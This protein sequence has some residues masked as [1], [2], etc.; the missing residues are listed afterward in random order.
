MA[1]DDDLE[2]FE[3]FDF[4][5]LDIDFD[6]D[7]GSLDNGKKRK[8][9]DRHPIEDTIKD[10]YNAAVDN[11]KSKK[12]RDHASGI[13][14]K[15]LSTDAKASAYELKSELDK[16]TEETKKQLEP[17]K[18]SLSSIS[19]GVSKM[20]PEGK[21]KNILKDFSDKLKGDTQSFYTEQKETLQDFQSSIQDAMSGVESQIANLSLAAGSSKQN[22]AN[23]LL[24]KQYIALVTAKEQDKIFYNKSLE[25][26]WRTATGVEETLKFQREQ[27]QT[28]TKQFEAIIQN[29]SLPEAVK[30][31][32]TELAGTVLKQKAF[33]SM[34]ETLYKRI[35][36]LE[37]FSNA[38]N[39]KMRNYIENAKD[40]T[41]SLEDLVG[42]SDTMSDLD[43]LG[44]S[45][46]GAAGALGSDLLLDW[47]YGKAGKMLPKSIRNKVEGNLNAAAANPLDYLR[48]LRSNNAKGL[49]GKLFNK[50]MGFLE[51]DLDTRNKFSNIKINKAELDS[52]ALFDG[53]T[54]NTINTVIPML[55]SKIHNEVYGLRTGKSVSEDT[56]LTFD[57]KTQSFITNKDMRKQLRANIAT[58]MIAVARRAAVGMKKEVV[59]RCKNIETANKD[60]IFSNLDKAFISYITE[61]GSISP[62]AMTTTK[63]LQF[64]PDQY[65]LE[66]AEL[67]NAFLFSLR[68]GGNSKGTYEMFSRSGEML[69]LSPMLLDKYATGMNANMIAKEGLVDYNSLTGGATL[70]VSGIQSRLHRAARTKR[71]NLNS[72]LRED[73][74]V[75]DINLR[76]DLNTDIENLKQYY[77]RARD[78]FKNGTDMS[79]AYSSRYGVA[80][81]YGDTPEEEVAARE[82]ETLRNQFIKDFEENY[83]N[84]ELKK[85]DP[86][87]YERK[88]Q[89]ELKKWNKS[90]EPKSLLSKVSS[91]LRK[92]VDEHKDNPVIL[93]LFKAKAKVEEVEKQYGPKALDVLDKAKNKANANIEKAKT[94]INSEDGLKSDVN[95]IKAKGREHYNAAKAKSIAFLDS[96]GIPTNITMDQATS[97]L[98]DKYNTAYTATVNAYN[99]APDTLAEFQKKFRTEYIDKL[100]K[101]LPPEELE[102]AKTYINSTDP[103][104]VMQKVVDSANAGYGS[105]KEIATL[106]IR[107]VN[108]DPNAIQELKDKVENTST[109]A[110]KAMDELQ[111]Q[112]VTIVDNSTKES[113]KKAKQIVD[114]LKGSDKKQPSDYENYINAIKKKKASDRT[115][116]EQQDLLDYRVDKT[117]NML[118]SALGALK[119]PMG[120]M[121]KQASNLAMWGVKSAIR[122]PLSGFAKGSRAFERK[123]YA[124]ALKNGI[125]WLLKSPFTL[126]KG[127]L[128]TGTKLAKGGA[129]LL[130]GLVDNPIANFMRGMDK[131]L[132]GGG[133]DDHLYGEDD[134]DSP[135]N[136]NSWWNRLK[137]TGKAVKDKVMPNKT[138]KKDNSFFSKLK[139]WLGPILGIATTAIGAIS[140]GVTKVAGLL[141]TGFSTLTGLGMRIV[142]ALTTVLGP[143]GKLLGKS[144]VKLGGAAG[145]GAAKIAAA[146]VKTKAGQAVVEGAAAA[147]SKIAKTSLAKKII[148]I[149]E[150]FKGTILKRLG[151]K[152]G[153]KLVAS[154]LGKIASRA[155][156]ILGWGL[157][158][159]DAA[160]AIKYMTVDGLSI[161][162][163][164]SKAVLGFDLFD[165]NDP[166]VDENGEPIKP[167]EPDVAKSKALQAQAEEDS[168]KKE[169]G[170][171]VVDNKAV[172]KE[173]FEKAQAE[174]KKRKA[175]GEDE[176]KLYSKVV[177]TEDKTV[178]QSRIKYKDFLHAL[179]SLPMADRQLKLNADLD[180]IKQNFGTLLEGHLYDLGEP[181]GNVHWDVLGSE[182]SIVIKNLNDGTYRDLEI[183]SYYDALKAM[184][185]DNV[186]KLLDAV[187]GSSSWSSN[188]QAV[189][190]EWLKKKINSI[191][192]AILEKAEKLKGSGIMGILKGLLDSIFGGKSDIPKQNTNVPRVNTGNNFDS[193]SNTYMDN[194]ATIG[195]SNLNFS[196]NGVSIYDKQGSSKNRKE[197]FDKKNLL[198]ITRRAMERAGWGPTEQA[199]FLAQITHETGNFRYMEELASGEAYEGRRDL[200]NTQPGDGMRYKGRGL[201]QVT[202]RANY[203]KIG[204]MLGLDL[205]NNPELIANDPK[206]AVDASM[207]WWELKKK[208]SK[209]FRESI[210]NGDIVSNTR[211][212]NGGYNGL[213]ERTAYYNQYKEF[214]AKN[215]T[216][217]NPA[218]TPNSDQA[219]N[220]G[221]QTSSGSFSGDASTVVPSGD[222]KVDAMV[223]AINSTATPQSRGKCA[224]A[225]REA[226]DAGGFKTADGQTVTQAFRDKGLAGSAY[227]YDSNGIL[228]SVGF[229]KID[230]NTTPATGDIEVFPGSSASPHGHIQVYNGNNWVSDFNQNGGSM[231]RPYGAPGSKYAGITPNMYRYSGSSP[232]PD[233]AMASKPDGVTVNSTDSSTTQAA[234]AGSNIL[235]KSI[236][237]GNATQTQQLDVQKQ[238]L[239]ALTALNNTI[240]AKPSDRIQDTRNAVNNN[241]NYTGSKNDRQVASR[242]DYLYNQ[243][244]GSK[245]AADNVLLDRAKQTNSRT[246]T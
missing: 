226:L 242:S 124:R 87:E 130:G 235:A 64:I 229:S 245:L 50:G 9:G 178:S 32:N 159:Y 5:D 202:G 75:Y 233:D 221:Y 127:V 33:N 107:A 224:T 205:V 157:L 204:K 51:D 61:Y 144:A 39:K 212:V 151:S 227:M 191:M 83:E 103:R 53:R 54:H 201:I 184:G 30:M 170:L 164:V 112:L 114:K 8:K 14:S 216:G 77:G 71:Y 142:S 104:E 78:A 210:E 1:K 161:G 29:T 152:A 111:D 120:W 40:V 185:N 113:K 236:D 175:N 48:S 155:V 86:V 199:L 206:V 214:L 223:S 52:Q 188:Q 115:P 176:H 65:Q 91:S 172:T 34:S 20:M 125:P 81:T 156:P 6:S 228:S 129:S 222:P 90:R 98:K 58:D 246:G 134:P 109:A 179:N 72:Q 18:K 49:F 225:V 190:L 85:K 31:R 67:F 138:D 56:E 196:S 117:Y 167:D 62:E 211:G 163:A 171:Y 186:N 136:K 145:A 189:Y 200:G 132:W 15:S 101:I 182:S 116:Q 197:G 69:K 239:D 94:Y 133:R 140:S 194:K 26:Q 158:L 19:S 209:K 241:T 3:D 73:Y 119:N 74:E 162:S 89:R 88:L 203:E 55:L 149:L 128:N 36:P 105:A 173:E 27:F 42:L 231:N 234:D 100:A 41:G 84:I 240:G 139:G 79:H 141:T 76:E 177:I 215:G 45:K 24:K 92:Y 180:G 193:R 220:Q 168:K 46:A 28:F 243:M 93:N 123:L 68:N 165:D 4:D 60:K 153:A 118:G 97:Y 160:K 108:G 37:T 13:I 38:I 23:E 230:P 47:F 43:S 10:T 122:F 208:E 217:A 174:N 126:G 95:N 57:V 187:T 137:S 183:S 147:S 59:E 21:I 154:L 11:I 12:L 44:M 218:D 148:S 213:G 35:S 232:V 106:G 22:L 195:S 219:L 237:A 17:V 198:D 135:A 150:G 2:G 110:K 207:A 244:N 16:I 7:S 166:A 181:L 146:A 70:N 169:T 102:K 63:F 131:K 238:M 192:D 82:Y 96:K 143:I 66:A 121:A 25:L 80:I 99:K